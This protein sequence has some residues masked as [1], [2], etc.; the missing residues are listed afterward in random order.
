MQEDNG[1]QTIGYVLQLHVTLRPKP[2]K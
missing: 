1:I 2:W